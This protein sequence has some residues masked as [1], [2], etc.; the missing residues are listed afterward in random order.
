MIAEKVVAKS[1]F[2]CYTVV[3]LIKYGVVKNG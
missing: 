3:S 1:A 2:V